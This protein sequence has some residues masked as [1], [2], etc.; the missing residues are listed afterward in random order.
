MA[1]VNMEDLKPN[2]HTYKSEQKKKL[3]PAIKGGGVVSTRKPLSKKFAETFIEEDIGDIKDYIIFD[4]IIPGIKNLCLDALEMIFFGGTRGRRRRSGGR[5]KD[6]DEY[7]DYTSHYKSAE[8]KRS[9]RRDDGSYDHDRKDKVDYRNI[10]LK[11]SDDAKDVVDQL[12]GR[13]KDYGQATVADL[14]DLVDITGK[15][16]DNNWG[17]TNQSDIGIARV[18]NGYLIDVPEAQLLDD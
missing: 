4:A 10:V 8:Y 3:A 13:I 5:V 7:Y 11:Y 17:W 14:F 12:R 2:S 16:T 9:R 1:K 15:Y 18:S 6:D